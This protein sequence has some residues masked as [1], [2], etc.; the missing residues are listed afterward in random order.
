[1]NNCSVF[2]ISDCHQ[3]STVKRDS[4]RDLDDAEIELLR[5]RTKARRRS[6]KTICAYHDQELLS[7]FSSKRKK[8]CDPHGKHP[9]KA[10]TK[11]LKIIS[12]F[13]YRNFVNPPENVVPGEKVCPDCL[14]KLKQATVEEPADDVNMA[15]VDDIVPSHE[16]SDGERGDESDMKFSSPEKSSSLLAVNSA[17]LSLDET[18]VKLHQLPVH[19]KRS[20]GKK[21]LQLASG[22]LKKKL[23]L[24][25]DVSLSS[26]DSEDDSKDLSMYKKMME[27]LKAKFGASDSYKERVQIL[28]VSPFTIKRT[29]E[30]FG[31]T[32]YMVKKSRDVRKEKGI[33]GQCDKNKGKVLS[34]DIRQAVSDF[35]EDDDYSRIMPGK[36]DFVSVKNKDGDKDRHQKRLILTNL[37]ELYAKWKDVHPDKKIG[38]STFASLRPKWCIFA[39]KS[40]THSVCVCKYHQNPKLMAASCLTCS[41]HDVME[42]CVCSIASEKCMMGQCKDCPGK[43]GLVDYLNECDDLKDRDE[44]SYQQ[45]ISTDRTALVTITETKDDFIENFSNQILKL[46]RHSFT[47]KAQSKYMNDLK[48][49]MPPLEDVIMQGDFAENYAYVVQDEIQSFHWENKQATVHPFVAYRRREDGTLEHRNICIISDCRDHNADTVHAFLQ[50]VN[51]YLK[52][53]YPEM[54]KIHYFTD[55]CAGQY[56][57][58]YNFLNLC[59]HSED[60]GLCAEW[61]FFAT[62]HGKSACDGIGGTVKRLLTKA[63]LQRP[64]QDA[65]LT[66]DAIMKFCTE[67]IPGIHFINVQP[68]VVTEYEQKLK[69][70]KDTAKTIEGTQKFHRYVPDSKSSVKV[71]KLSQQEED[72]KIVR[73]SSVRHGEPDNYELGNDEPSEFEIST[74]NYVCAMYDEKPWIGLVDEISEEHGDYSI[75]FMHPHGPTKFLAWPEDT[76]KCWIERSDIL[77]TINAPLVVSSGQRIRYKISE[78]ESLKIATICKKWT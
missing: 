33:L 56:K 41:V 34:E 35:Y 42:H 37:A 70:R 21:K 61:N 74:Q 49:T 59:F 40:G 78:G 31:A 15:D 73:V 3:G 66:T 20:T 17:L 44:I 11:S 36:K 45:W 7:K 32:N 53:V 26:S 10:R 58:K 51:P 71:Y 18:P 28:T 55:G 23:E 27:E 75:N 8:C 38:F 68:S 9:T 64:Y 52:T 6:I 57:N 63:S 2:F 62:S 47:S 5:L 16:D 14:I 19:Q 50:S 48:M 30:E 39:G 24:S 46:T 43:Q 25:Y 13:Q 67:N 54:K 22:S 77:C 69:D 60:F 12:L 1:M 29:M 4:L 65:I 72:P 76:D